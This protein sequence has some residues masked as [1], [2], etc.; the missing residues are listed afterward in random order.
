M[1]KWVFI[2]VEKNPFE[3]K[4]DTHPDA[5]YL[6]EISRVGSKRASSSGLVYKEIKELLNH[7]GLNHPSEL[8][9]KTFT[10]PDSY[11]DEGS[12]LNYLIVTIRAGGNYQA[13]THEQLY[14]RAASALAQMKCPDFSDV[15]NQTVFKAFS[16]VF[17]D[18]SPDERWFE[19]FKKKVSARSGG[20]VTIEQANISDFSM[21]IMGPAV[22][23][24]LASKEKSIKFTFGPYDT[25]FIFCE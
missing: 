4:G 23:L 6:W 17:S 1:N 20:K 18:H 22:Y 24:L 7:Y 10:T 13:P 12:A 9:G 3:K 19:S 14:E 21:R 11:N 25:P 5:N 2:K 15:D 8:A 16:R